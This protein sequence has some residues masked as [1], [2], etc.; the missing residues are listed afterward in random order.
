MSAKAGIGITVPCPAELRCSA[1]RFRGTRNGTEQNFEMKRGTRNGT[2]QNL[3]MKRGTRNGMGQNLEM[4][5]GTRN[6]TE[7]F[8]KWSRNSCFASCSAQFLISFVVQTLH[9]RRRMKI[10]KTDSARKEL[11]YFVDVI[12]SLEKGLEKRYYF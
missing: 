5:R 6:G 3:E 9:S 2:G 11:I 8:F 12:I 4:K 1:F 7:Q 10:N